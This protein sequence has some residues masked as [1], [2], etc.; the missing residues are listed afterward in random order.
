VARFTRQHA[1]VPLHVILVK[2]LAIVLAWALAVSSCA[3][4]DGR[5]AFD[6]PRGEMLAAMKMIGNPFVGPER[7]FFFYLQRI[8]GSGSVLSVYEYRNGKIVDVVDRGTVETG[9][10]LSRLAAIGFKPFDYDAEVERAEAAKR[11]AR[12]DV[13]T[14]VL[15]GAEWEV[16]IA[17]DAGRFA[18]RKL[19]PSGDFANYAP[20][21]E[22]I[23]KLMAVVELLSDQYGKGKIGLM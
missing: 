20:Y 14:I 16:T 8:P 5:R 13:D 12:D 11:S 6:P 2:R 19:N 4:E 3:H 9:E 22:D 21:S 23:A 18:V 10:F 15:D 1:A 17:T 7:G